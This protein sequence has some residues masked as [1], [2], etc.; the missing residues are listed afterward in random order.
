M[1]D[2]DMRAEEIARGLISLRCNTERP[3]KD[4]P[5][6]LSLSDCLVERP[7][8]WRIEI[9]E[10][11]TV[12]APGPDQAEPHCCYIQTVKF[13]KRPLRSSDGG[14]CDLWDECDTRLSWDDLVQFENDA[15]VIGGGSVVWKDGKW[16]MHR[17]ARRAKGRLVARHL[18]EN[19]R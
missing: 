19:P 1:T 18:Q 10:P 11:L 14:E 13:Y 17:I 12:S 15:F 4:Y 2:Q 7:K 5:S 16:W 3:Y 8:P 6:D 9:M